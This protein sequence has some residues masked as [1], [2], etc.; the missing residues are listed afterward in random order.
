M[1]E[2]IKA[3][4]GIVL[5]FLFVHFSLMGGIYL[6]GYMTN[7]DVE[8]NII[9]C[10]I[11]K[12]FQKTNITTTQKIETSKE[13]YINGERVNCSNFSGDEHF[14]EKGKCSMN[15]VCPN[16]NNNLSIKECINKEEEK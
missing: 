9:Y 1:N 5:L 4:I 16:P 8:C 12:D 6:Y 14:C 13:C 2:P 7:S 15:G 3:I 11:S 10:T